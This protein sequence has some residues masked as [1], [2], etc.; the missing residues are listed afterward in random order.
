M[1]FTDENVA[2][3]GELFPNCVT[4][5][6]KG[7][8]K[9]IDFDLLKQE[10]SKN[11]VDGPQERYRLDWPGKREALVTAN[12]PIT[13]T[14]RPCPEE[15]VDFDETEN[16][17]IEGD[18]LEAL[19]LLQNTYLGKVKMI[20]IDP[21]YNTGKDFVYSDNFTVDK[22][23]FLE[24]SGQVDEEG[25]KLVANTESNGRFHSDWLSM[26]Y[27]R[28]KL[29]RNLL[30]DDGMIFISIDDNEQ[31]NLRKLC[32]EVFGEDNFVTEFSWINNERGRSIDRFVSNTN[33]S[34]FMFSK[35]ILNLSVN[36]LVEKGA[37][38][39]LAYD[40]EDEYSKYKRGDP[41]YNNNTKFNI[42]TRPNLV[43]SIYIN[44]ITEE[45]KCIDEKITQSNGITILPKE[46]KLGEDWIKVTPPLRKNINKLGCWRWGKEKFDLES[47]KELILC[48]NTNSGLYMFFSKNRL[49]EAGEKL[50]KYKNVIRGIHGGSG[51]NEI[52]K[53]LDGKYFDHPKPSLLIK[54]LLKLASKKHDLILDFFA[55]SGTSAHAVMQLNAEDGGNRKFI[56][57]QIPEECNEKSEAFEAGYKTIA[58]IS[59]ER[60][61]RAGTKIKEEFE[62]KKANGQM[63]LNMGDETVAKDASDLD[64][65]FRVLKVDSSNM[66]DVYYSPEKLK[67]GELLN[68]QENIKADRTSEDLLFQV[69]LDWGVDLTL[70]ITREIIK[71]DSKEFEVFFVDGNSLAACFVKNSE[72]DEELCKVLAERQPQRIVFRDSG[73]AN[74]DVKINVEQIFKQLS[75][76]TDVKTI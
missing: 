46:N 35:S 26:M 24:E 61:R 65:G 64:I 48:K 41:L 19:K 15:S 59:K 45:Y 44:K 9:S 14:L 21:P 68:F 3:I 34:I 54:R 33:E 56:M 63:E 76:H 2:K 16:L 11:I 73:F 62:L 53:L 8:E 28:L 36:L 38:I 57:V 47:K 50:S 5:A 30:R 37:D 20:Y 18:N 67:Q 22:A 12:T 13:K 29:A 70:P 6:A 49:T 42:D 43:Y 66:A 55:G 10:L 7:E 72:I 58:E 1:N 71:T 60:I 74:D 40:L 39:L 25:G 32:N 31:S 17:F 23:E 52:T 69:L 75:P 27:P 4:E 51:T